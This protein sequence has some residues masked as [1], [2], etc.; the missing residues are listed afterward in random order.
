MVWC[1][2]GSKIGGCFSRGVL[3]CF[4]VMVK[5]A[6]FPPDG[7]QQ[8]QSLGCVLYGAA[9]QPLGCFGPSGCFLYLLCS[10]HT[11]TLEEPDVAAQC[12]VAVLSSRKQGVWYSL[13]LL[14][15]QQP[16]TCTHTNRH[17]KK[18]TLKK[19]NIEIIQQKPKHQSEDENVP[20]NQRYL[21]QWLGMGLKIVQL[22]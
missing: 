6:A 10:L 12:F 20:L 1:G 16:D 15:E 8:P 11:L 13:W 2:H 7:V 22:L 3:V 5:K 14:Y 19:W 17:I 18:Q 4:G 9:G 21:L